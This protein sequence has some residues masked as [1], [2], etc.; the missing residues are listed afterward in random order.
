M[1]ASTQLHV[2][3]LRFA[4]SLN[5]LRGQLGL[6]LL[7]ATLKSLDCC[8][9][10]AACINLRAEVHDDLPGLANGS[11]PRQHD[12]A[13]L[14]DGRNLARLQASYAALVVALGTDEYR[15]RHRTPMPVAVAASNTAAMQDAGD[16]LAA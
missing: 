12:F 3:L 4:D 9:I 15:R 5:N 16:D 1:N 10:C 14:K 6:K 8:G 7:E 11:A 13:A 2:A